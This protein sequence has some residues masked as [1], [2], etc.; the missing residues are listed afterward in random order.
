MSAAIVIV[1]DSKGNMRSSNLK[2]G[3]VDT[4]Y[5]RCGFRRADDFIVRHTWKIPDSESTID[6]YARTTVKQ[7]MRTNMICRHLRTTTCFSGL[8]HSSGRLLMGMWKILA[9]KSGRR[10]YERLFGGFDDLAATAE[11]DEVGGR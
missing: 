4:V 10:A 5:K 11:A 6:L 7:V 3:A 2:D 9:L 8:S 1:S